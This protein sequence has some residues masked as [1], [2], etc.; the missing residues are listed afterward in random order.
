MRIARSWRALRLGVWL[1]VP[2]V[3]MSQEGALPAPDVS[4]LAVR[5]DSLVAI[6]AT[7]RVGW[8]R[9]SLRRT[10]QGG[11]RWA[12]TIDVDDAV[13]LTTL[14]VTDAQLGWRQ[15][16]QTGDVW[17]R[18]VA[19]Q[20][21]TADGALPELN[22]VPMLVVATPWRAGLT[23]AWRVVDAASGSVVTLAVACEGFEPAGAAGPAAWRVVVTRGATR[24]R[25]RVSAE[26]PWR[27]LGVATDGLPFRFSLP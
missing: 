24:T 22:L 20:R 16:L 14:V 1:A 23:G 2:G 5:R 17:D 21:D 8:M 15:L 3:A 25:Y 19:S 27:M 12:E 26:A 10:P 18:S 4:R 7:G 13:S 6:A 9:T 11:W